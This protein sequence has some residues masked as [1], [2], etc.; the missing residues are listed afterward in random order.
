MNIVECL[1]LE[2]TTVVVEAKYIGRS[3][4]VYKQFENLKFFV[5]FGRLKSLNPFY[6]KPMLSNGLV[7][8]TP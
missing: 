8:V 4:A 7:Q 3:V 6:A 1:R 5:I 2:T